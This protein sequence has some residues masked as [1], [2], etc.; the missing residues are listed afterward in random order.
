MNN[1]A[2]FKKKITVLVL[3]LICVVVPIIAGCAH[4][5]AAPDNQPPTTCADSV[6]S[7]FQSGKQ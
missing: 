2:T 4:A 3:I 5:E 6:K 1:R 7:T